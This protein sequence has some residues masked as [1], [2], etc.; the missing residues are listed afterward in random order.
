MNDQRRQRLI[1]AA[2][3]YHDQGWKLVVLNRRSKAPRDESWQRVKVTPRD[4]DSADLNIGVQLGKCSG[5]LCDV[6][7]DCDEARALAPH[8]LERTATFGR[9]S[10]PRSHHLYVTNLHETEPKGVIKFDAPNGGRLLELRTG[11]GGKGIQTMMPPSIHAEGE[12]VKW[13]NDK[14][15]AEVDGEELKRRVAALAAA[16]LLLRYYPK[17]GNRHEKMLSLG[18]VL[19]RASTSL[20]KRLNSSFPVCPRVLPEDLRARSSACCRR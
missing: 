10:S 15:P 18:G 3:D 8:F 16:C 1:D 19:A 20:E 5:G 11:G 14:D 9:Q 13:D 7:L 17:E 12:P 4:F 6:D 2:Q